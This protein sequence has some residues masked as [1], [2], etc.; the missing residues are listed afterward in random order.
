MRIT[1]EICRNYQRGY[2]RF[3]EQCKYKHPQIGD[4]RELYHQPPEE[5]RKSTPSEENNQVKENDE[6]PCQFYMRGDCKLGNFCQ[7][8]H[9]NENNRINE[10]ST[11]NEICRNYQR[12]YC[13]FREQCKYKHITGTPKI[14]L[15]IC[16]DYER[17]RCRFGDSFIYHH[18]NHPQKQPYNKQEWRSNQDRKLDEHSRNNT[19]NNYGNDSRTYHNQMYRQNEIKSSSWSSTY[20]SNITRDRARERDIHMNEYGNKQNDTAQRAYCRYNEKGYCK[21][22]DECRFEHRKVC[23]YYKNGTCRNEDNCRFIHVEKTAPN[24][25]NQV[26]QIPTNRE[27]KPR[28]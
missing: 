10:K 6:R 18:K 16:R 22:G 9:A 19:R 23:Y 17:G 4:T 1:S 25:H 24:H 20:R 5:Y 15:E 13:K 7:F 28:Y 21:Y 8:K 3:R 2:C 14:P 11:L 26:N 12:G 27:R